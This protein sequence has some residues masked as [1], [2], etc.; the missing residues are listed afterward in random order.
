MYVTRLMKVIRYFILKIAK[1]K[2]YISLEF[3]GNLSQFNKNKLFHN[4]YYKLK[5]YTS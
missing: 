3:V 1:K 2:I 4:I 5:Q